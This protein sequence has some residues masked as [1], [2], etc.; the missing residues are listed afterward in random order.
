MDFE[1]DESNL[2]WE[3]FNFH[4]ATY[5][6]EG[7]SAPVP[8]SET[9]PVSTSSTEST[10]VSPSIPASIIVIPG[11]IQAVSDRRF[12]IDWSEKDLAGKGLKRWKCTHN[13][14]GKMSKRLDC[15]LRHLAKEHD[16]TKFGCTSW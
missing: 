16:G 2:V 5:D 8:A 9:S 12:V 3:D 10:P 6:D 4:G 7:Y 13:G 11:T 15:H 1:H 14:C